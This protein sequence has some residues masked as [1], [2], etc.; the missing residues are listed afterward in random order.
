MKLRILFGS[1]VWTLLVTVLHIWAN[2]GFTEF[3]ADIRQAVGA[4][5][6]QLR[7]GFLPVT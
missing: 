2:I 4:E 5:R 1:L 6:Q 7:V 3:A